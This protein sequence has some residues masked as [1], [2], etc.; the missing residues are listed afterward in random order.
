MAQPRDEAGPS[1]VANKA[2]RHKQS[3]DE[4]RKLRSEYRAFQKTVHRD[5]DDLISIDK[6]EKL[7]GYLENLNYLNTRVEGPRE[8]AED[9]EC[10]FVLCQKG[11]EAARRVIGAGKGRTPND[12]IRA[13]KTEFVATAHPQEDGANIPEAFNWAAL[14]KLAA[15]YFK[16][17]PGISCMLGPMDAAPK[18]RKVSV[19]QPKKPLGAL[20]NPAEIQIA[21]TKDHSDKNA[22]DM[23]LKIMERNNINLLQCIINHKSFSQSVENL[24]AFSF[25][26]KDGRVALSKAAGGGYMVTALT[27]DESNRL[28]KNKERTQAIFGFDMDTWDDWCTRVRPEDCI[29]PHRP[30]A[31]LPNGD[32]I[33]APAGEEAAG[34]SGLP[35]SRKRA[36]PSRR[37]QPEEESEGESEEEED[38]E[39][40]QAKARKG[41]KKVRSA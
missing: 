16:H 5:G 12:L 31:I 39:A 35:A 14:S 27:D 29:M 1:A 18:L 37:P 24:F 2:A 30:P 4:S 6:S 25:L 28:G 19:R 33:S 15:R 11:A 32:P 21:N 36:P 17:A 8:Q 20:V 3:T 41:K 7:L 9:T 13:L 10:F 34:G 38:E 22:E 40:K 23:R 26:V